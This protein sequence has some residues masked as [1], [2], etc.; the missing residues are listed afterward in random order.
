MLVVSDFHLGEGRRNWDGTINVLEDFT[1]DNRFSEF[2]KHYS[3][4][5]EEVELVLAGN[6][7]EMLRCRAAPDY[8]D[9]L[10][11]TYALEQVRVAM[12]GHPKVIQA[13]KEF[14]QK[15]GNSLV[16]LIGEADVGVLWPRVQNEIRKRISNRVDFQANDYSRDGIY[17]QHGHQYDA[18]FGIDYM[19]PFKEVD[20]VDVLKLPWGAFYYAN[21]IQPLRR[22]RPLFYRVR[23]MRTYLVWA[24]L[25][26]TRFLMKIIAQF[27]KMWGIASSRKLLPGNSF[28]G[29][30]K[31]FSQAADSEALEK[32]AE[33]LL[34]SDTTQKVIFGHSHIANYRQF[35]NGKEYF[36]TGTWTRNL[37]LD[38]RSLGAF[39]KLT[40]VLIEY[41]GEAQEPQ[42]KMMEWHG[43][44]Q[45]IADYM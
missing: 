22:I 13:L 19:S 25:F 39:H 10:F 2:L 18:M 6:F 15:E 30:L 32:Y 44:H 37:S 17:I 9:V 38:M 34:A 3:Q 23:P 5:Y 24:F 26:E 27:L 45:V 40:Y 7:F 36:N 41:V 1:V 11:E 33:V 43:K 21:F 16:Y 35:R 8:P 42:A 14:M 29:I 28:L 4:A 12:D 20:G 31:I